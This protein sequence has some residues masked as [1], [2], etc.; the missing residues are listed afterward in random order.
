MPSGSIYSLFRGVSKKQVDNFIQEI[1]GSSG[2]DDDAIHDNTAGEIAAITEKATPVDADLLL[3]EDS[4]AGNA[5]KRTQVGNVR[6]LNESE[7]DA[8]VVAVAGNSLNGQTIF[9]G[10]VADDDVFVYD[11]EGQVFAGNFIVTINSSVSNNRGIFSFRAATSSAFCLSIASTGITATTGVLTG[12]TGSDGTVTVS[13]HTD[14]KLYIE[15][16][17]GGAINFSVTINAKVF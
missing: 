3:L 6:G 2:T 11:F 7:V 10:N 4:E 5:K 12:T 8:R 14:Q 15:N 1:A 16:R 13:T 9:T 17:R